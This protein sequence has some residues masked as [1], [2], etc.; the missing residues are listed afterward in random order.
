[1]NICKLT[2][3][4]LM[5]VAVTACGNPP[6]SNDNFQ[7]ELSNLVSAQECDKAEKLARDN[8]RRFSGG[9]N[10]MTRVV[11]VIYAYCGRREKGIAYLQ[12]AARQGDNTAAEALIDLGESVPG[13]DRRPSERPKT[14]VVPVPQAPA[15]A[16]TVEPAFTPS[17]PKQTNCRRNGPTVQCTTY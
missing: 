13:I 10:K 17:M 2:F 5:L 14:V 11:G 16:P 7:Q 9:E 15:A 3:N 12:L 4:I 8:P 1:M 6:K